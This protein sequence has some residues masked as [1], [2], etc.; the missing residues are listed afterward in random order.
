MIVGCVTVPVIADRG[1]DSDVINRSLWG[2]TQVKEN[3]VHVKGVL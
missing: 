2:D 1:S 3:C